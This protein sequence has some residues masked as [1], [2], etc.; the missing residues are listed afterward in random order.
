[1]KGEHAQEVERVKEEFK[2]KASESQ[3][4]VERKWE[5]KLEEV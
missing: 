3:M 2:S 4:E 1:M 5:S